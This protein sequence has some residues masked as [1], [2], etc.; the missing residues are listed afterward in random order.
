MTITITARFTLQHF[1]FLALF[2]CCSAVIN[3]AHAQHVQGTTSTS[4]KS[5]LRIDS[6]ATQST[7]D[8]QFKPLQELAPLSAAPS[9][10]ATMHKDPL[11]AAGL[12]FLL[13]GAG[14]FYVEAPW[15]KVLLFVGGTGFVAAQ[16]FLFH[17]EFVRF[18][19][20]YNALPPAQQ[21][22][23]TGQQA[24]RLREVYSDAR[25][26]FAAVWLGLSLF[27]AVDAYTGAHL[28]EFD[29]SDDL[30]VSLHA[31]PTRIGFAVHW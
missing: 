9:T 16:T 30:K 10:T 19:N 31:S 1:L 2:L 4:T 22:S 23:L 28:Y 8:R 6:S 13:P 12:S 7:T 21:S 17:A 27:A 29:V 15:W 26:T 25:D 14:Q 11:L 24:L 20:A 3:M 5:A 18:N